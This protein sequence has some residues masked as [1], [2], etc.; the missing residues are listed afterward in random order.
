MPGEGDIEDFFKKVDVAYHKSPEAVWEH[1]TKKIDEQPLAVRKNYF[2][3]PWISIAAVFLML[4]GILAVLKYYTIEIQSHKGEH[5]VYSLPDGSKVSLNAES[6]LT[7]H[8]FWWRFS[9]K[10][11]IEGEAFF[12]IE[13]GRPFQAVSRAGK[14][15]VLGTSFNIYSRNGKYQVSCFTGKVKV[16]SPGKQEAMLLPFFSAEILPDG[17]ISVN[18]FTDKI[19]TTDWMNNMFSFTSVPLL[20]V[21]KEVER[22]YNIEIETNVSPDLI[23]TGHFQGKRDVDE[24]LNLLC[25]PFGLK[26]EKI[27][28][29]RYRIN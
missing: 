18:E 7:F 16:V 29:R 27:S 2:S 19:K 12:A 4:F 9:R 25:K 6:K 28:E 22:Q 26:F 23:Y 21:I 11:N 5:L 3:R 1:L 17:K 10:L 20:S 15:V 8:P 13:K 14:T 24:I